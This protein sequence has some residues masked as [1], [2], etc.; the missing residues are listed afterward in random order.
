MPVKQGVRTRVQKE[1]KVKLFP[2]LVAEIYTDNEIKEWFAE[3]AK[4]DPKAKEWFEYEIRRKISKF[5]RVEKN[6]K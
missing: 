5:L 6:K 1:T 4:D 2:L 3:L